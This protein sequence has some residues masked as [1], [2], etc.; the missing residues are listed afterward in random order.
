MPIVYCLLFFT[1]TFTKMIMWNFEGT[2]NK[3]NIYFNNTNTNTTTTTT[4]NNNIIII[5]KPPIHSKSRICY[6]AE[7]HIKHIVAGCATLA[8][9]E[10][11]TRHNGQYVDV[12]CSGYWQVL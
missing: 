1:W 8:P 12:W 10:Y 2:C 7:E 6:V 4:N 5:M 11:A 9:F 3:C